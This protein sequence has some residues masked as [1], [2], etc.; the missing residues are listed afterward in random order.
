MEVSRS[1]RQRIDINTKLIEAHLA[2]LD[3]KDLSSKLV[4]L[5]KTILSMQLNV[6][7]LVQRRKISDAQKIQSKIEIL[8]EELFFRSLLD[9]PNIDLKPKQKIALERQP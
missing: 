3:E 4:E 5:E 7:G 9:N 8:K 6:N 1:M 2:E